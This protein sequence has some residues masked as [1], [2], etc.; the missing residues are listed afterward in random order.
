M[1]RQTMRVW[2][3]SRLEALTTLPLPLSSAAASE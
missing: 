3:K 1:A 2:T